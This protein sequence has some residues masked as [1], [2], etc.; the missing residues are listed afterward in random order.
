[1]S[2]VK[3]MDPM[4]YFPYEIFT[5]IVRL[6][7]FGIPN[8]PSPFLMTSY[9]LPLHET[10][11]PQMANSQMGRAKPSRTAHAWTNFHHVAPD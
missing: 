6:A 7:A 9:R 11:L 2:G 10:V 1:M 8:G 4:D 5:N 3:N